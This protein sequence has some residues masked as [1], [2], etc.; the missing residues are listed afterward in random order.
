MLDRGTPIGIVLVITS[1]PLLVLGYPSIEV[2]QGGT[3]LW[4]YFAISIPLLLGMIAL[5]VGF[6]IIWSRLA[7]DVPKFAL[8]SLTLVSILFGLLLTLGSSLFATSG[9]FEVDFKG[10]PLPFISVVYLIGG[11][12]SSINIFILLFDFVFWFG[13]SFVITL[14]LRGVRK[15]ITRSSI[16]AVMRSRPS[17][18]EYKRGGSYYECCSA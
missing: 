3:S 17:T 5:P 10:F 18:G 14:A 13:I 8:L 9:T 15:I 1:V 6:A 11:L 12:F 4:Q 16:T 2:I 7:R